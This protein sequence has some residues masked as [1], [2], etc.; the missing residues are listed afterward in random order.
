M[1]TRSH[2]QILKFNDVTSKGSLGKGSANETLLNGTNG[3]DLKGSSEVNGS[4][5][6]KRKFTINRLNF[7]SW[8]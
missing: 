2:I 5:G 1:T 3:S 6:S 8:K 7:L 4:D